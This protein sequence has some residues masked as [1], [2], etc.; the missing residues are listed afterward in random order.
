M[1]NGETRD[2]PQHFLSLKTEFLARISDFKNLTKTVNE[3]A[4]NVCVGSSGL[5]GLISIFRTQHSRHPNIDL[6]A[7]V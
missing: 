5:I 4:V 6:K 2:F 3:Q 7:H 1:R